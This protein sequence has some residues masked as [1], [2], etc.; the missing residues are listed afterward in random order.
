[1]SSINLV[2]RAATD[3][4]AFNHKLHDIL[5]EEL[6]DHDSD[7][8]VPETKNQYFEFSNSYYVM[9]FIKLVLFIQILGIM[10]DHPSIQLAVLFN[11]FCRGILYYSIRFYSRPFLDALYVLHYFWREITVSIESQKL[12]ATPEVEIIGPGERRLNE[13]P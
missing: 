1:M 7:D 10:I 3:D 12:P 5:S 11:I 2:R 9:R 6:S 8:E 4:T 13:N